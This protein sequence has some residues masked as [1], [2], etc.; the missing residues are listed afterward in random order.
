MKYFII[1]ICFIS[2]SVCSQEKTDDVISF[3]TLFVQYTHS[4][5]MESLPNATIINSY[6]TLNNSNSIYEMDFMN[7]R[8]AFSEDEYE[9]NEGKKG[10]L[11]SIKPKVNDFIFKNSKEKISYSVSRIGMEPFLI[12]DSDSI[13]EWLVSDEYK[14]ILGY[15]CQKATTNFRGRNYTAFFSTDIPYQ[16]GPWKFGNL[17]GL[18]LE[19]Y[20]DDDVFK[21]TANKLFTKNDIALAIENP[22][23]KRLQE[24]IS[25]DIFINKYK[26]KFNEL[27][28]YRLPKGGTMSIPKKGIEVYI[29]N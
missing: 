19:V 18:I 25:W 7:N 21:I 26:N 12:K 16:N 4:I 2:S 10:V 8:D 3:Q 17:P 15:K 27:K 1:V 28:H 23:F 11:L 20:S 13:F 29:E 5:H 14:T 22:F 6:L 24:S 9:E